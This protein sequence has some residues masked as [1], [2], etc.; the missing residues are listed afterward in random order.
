MAYTINKFNGEQLIVLDDGTIDTSTSLGLVGRNYVGY[1]EI[2]NENFVFLLENFA[3]DAPPSRPLQGQIWYNN[4]NNLVYVYTN[5]TWAIVGAAV[6]SDTAPL[7]PTTGALWLRTPVNTLNVWTGSAWAFI[8]PEAVPGFGTTRARAGVVEDSNGNDRPVVFLEVNGSILGICSEAAFTINPATPIS[9]FNSNFII[10]INLSNTA[11]INGS[12]T[13]NASSADKLTTGRFINNVNFD[14]QSNITIKASTT[15]RLTKGD[16]ITGSNFDGSEPVTWSVDA[17]SA[18]VIGKVVVRNSEGGFAAGTITANL[19]GNLTGNVTSVG[20][21]RFNIIE[22]NQ[23]IGATLTGNAFSASQLETPRK[24]NGVNFNATQDITVTAAAETLTGNTL[25]STVTTSTLTSVGTLVN[26]NVNDTGINVGSSGQLQLIV[27]GGTPTVRSITGTLNFDI[28]ENGPDISFVNSL[29]SLSLGG[30]FEPAIL[31][32]NTTNLGINGYKFNNVYANNFL[33]NATTSTLAVSATN[34]VGGGLGAIPYQTSPG[35]T[36]MLGLGAAGTVLT[37]QAGS[38]AWTP[39]TRESLTKG[40]YLNLVNTSNPVAS[41]DSFNGLIAATLSVDATSINTASKVVARDSSGNFAAGTITASLVGNVT[42]NVTGNS[43]TATRLQTPRTIN[44]VSF[45]GTANIT[46]EANDPNSGAPV[47]AILYYPSATIPV[48]WMICD[49]ASLSTTTFS[50]LF[51]KI[52]YTFGGSGSVFRLPDLRGEFIRSWDGG[53]GVDAGRTLG[54]SQSHLFRSHQ[55]LTAWSQ[56]SPASVTNSVLYAGRVDQLGGAAAGF[57][58]VE[59]G[60]SGSPDADEAV[61]FTTATGGS[62]TR[63]RNIALVAC[64]K[65]FGE[66]DEPDQV[67]AAAIINSIASIPRYQVVSGAAQTVG[68]TNIVGSWNFNSNFFDV[69]P[70]AG[71]SMSNLAAFVPSIRVIQFN[72]VVNGDDSMVCT[73]DYFGDRIRVYV[74]NTEQRGRAEGNYLAIWS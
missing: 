45:D 43:G 61:M 33:G 12:I 3:N 74:Q 41:L 36:T 47:G 24:I 28:G 35:T 10:G 68:F 29:V 23:F 42:G 4:T 66:I 73:Y 16:Y 69:F 15:N 34:L 50:L 49:G 40:S 26:L 2:Q 31:G 14:G 51:S 11:K 52:G 5:T 39:V 7:E 46:I 65:V 27:D 17:T 9:N 20:T 1:G 21:S 19:V 6:L 72:G 64:I 56:D 30:P 37:A 63:P 62:E 54:S 38:I 67:A 57:R 25:N 8:G 55:H 13:G 58:D 32:D 71:K 59:A 18:N 48:G 53:R 22:A 70:P 60:S 44:G